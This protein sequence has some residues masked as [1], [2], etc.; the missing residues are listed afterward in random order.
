MSL[1]DYIVVG[2]IVAT[3][4]IKGWLTIRSFTSNPED[5]FNYTLEININNK[6]TNI[7]IDNY[8][9]MPKK[10]TMKLRALNCIE[11]A[12]D[13]ITKDILVHKNNLPQ[14]INGEYYWYQLINCMVQTHEN[15][16]I[17]LVTS[18]LRNGETDILII[19]S[20]DL[21][22]EIFIPFIKEYLIEVNLEDSLIIVKWNEEF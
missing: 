7:D 22:K 3:H 17:G 5:I 14:T 19:W 11:D 1:S 2:K 9:F 12:E 13:Y 21:K 4:G 18:L 10:I 15:V 20:D 6:I 16:K 8:N